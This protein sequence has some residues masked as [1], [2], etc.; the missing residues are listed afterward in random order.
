MDMPSELQAPP[1]RSLAAAGPLLD[2]GKQRARGIF[3][4]GALLFPLVI[5]IGYFKFGDIDAIIVAGALGISTLVEL[6]GMAMLVQAKRAANLF[7]NGV[8]SMGTIVKVKAPADRQGNAYVYIDVQFRDAGGQSVT[9]TI[10]TMANVSEL[11]AREGAE[12]PVLHIAGDRRMGIYTPKL[13]LMAGMI[14]A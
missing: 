14:K 6:M 12:V 1:P 8:A 9:G 3:I 2:K 7:S 5:A 10:T 13:G 11:D 4:G